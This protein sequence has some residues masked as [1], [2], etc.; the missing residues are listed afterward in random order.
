M[1]EEAHPVEDNK[2]GK[3]LKARQIEAEDLAHGQIVIVTGRWILVAAGLLLAL[4][5]PAPGRELRIEILVIFILAFANFFLHAQVLMRR[6]TMPLVIYA[7]SA[8]DI[9]VISIFVLVG[10][11]FESNL[12]TFY[13]PGILAF[14][15]AF[16]TLLT[17][18]YTLGTTLLYV[19]ISL[20]TM[21][22]GI[23]NAST[24]IGADLQVLVSRLMIFIT[25]GVCG[26]LYWRIE[27]NRRQ[28]AVGQT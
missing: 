2:I 23:L 17:L 14:S 9:I 28:A 12:F 25:V 1:S 22:P 16:P 8:I 5:N 11:G 27:G 4:W 19:V 6:T 3:R 26:N 10:G 20:A 13:L 18:A 15:V 7:A 24:V 21:S